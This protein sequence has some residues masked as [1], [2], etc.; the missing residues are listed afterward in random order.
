M[1]KLTSLAVLTSALVGFYFVGK[2]LVLSSQG[3]VPL[4]EPVVSQEPQ[5]GNVRLET[6]VKMFGSAVKSKIPSSK[7]EDS[8]LEAVIEGLM[9][10]KNVRLQSFVTKVFRKLFWLATR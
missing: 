5:E 4:I 8:E 9:I 3:A 2:A 10:T 6:G 1:N 7:V